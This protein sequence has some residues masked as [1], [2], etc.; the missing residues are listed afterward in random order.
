MRVCSQ[1]RD[2]LLSPNFPIYLF[3]GLKYKEIDLSASGHVELLDSDQS[4]TESGFSRWSLVVHSSLDVPI[5]GATVVK[6]MLSWS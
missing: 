6:L 5:Q 4:L 1:H 3:S 2:H